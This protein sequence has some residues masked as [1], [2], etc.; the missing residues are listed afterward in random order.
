MASWWGI[1]AHGNKNLDNTRSRRVCKPCSFDTIVL[2]LCLLFLMWI[3]MLLISGAIWLFLHGL[4]KVSEKYAATTSPAA[5]VKT[6]IALSTWRYHDCG[7][8]GMHVKIIN[9]DDY[10]ELFY[11]SGFSILSRT[12]LF[13]ANEVYSEF[14]FS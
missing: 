10:Y 4:A 9:H 5:G 3:V 13:L 11:P 12:L 1:E 14:P 2:Y 8:Y 7:G 6:D